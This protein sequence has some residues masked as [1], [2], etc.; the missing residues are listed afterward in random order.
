MAGIA[1]QMS[2]YLML[3]FIPAVIFIISI[4]SKLYLPADSILSYLE[5][6]MPK[7]AYSAVSTA[8]YEVLSS[9]VN[10]ATLLLSLWFIMLGIRGIVIGLAT[11]YP[12]TYHRHVVK[13]YVLSFIFAILFVIMIIASMLIIVFGKHVGTLIIHFFNPDANSILFGRILSYVVVFAI[14]VFS[15]ILLYKHAPN[16]KLKFKDIYVG[17]LFTS[18]GWVIS[19]IFFSFYINN[20]SKYGLIFGSLVGIFVFLLWLYLTTI[21]ILIGN[22]IN[23]SIYIHRHFDKNQSEKTK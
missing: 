4:A 18:S 21:I 9:N 16:I 3:S 12:E 15:F 7:S 23:V 2:Y 19:S 17:A 6:I 8:I 1:A 11:S 14:L 22:E 10:A 5:F 20:F 13:L